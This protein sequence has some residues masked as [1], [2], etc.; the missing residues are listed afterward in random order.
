[1]GAYNWLHTPVQCYNCSQVFTATL[2]VPIGWCRYDE[3][4]L[5]DHIV[6]MNPEDRERA[7]Q[8][9][10]LRT[11]IEIGSES[12]HNFAVST[13]DSHKCPNCGVKGTILVIV[14]DNIFREVRFTAKSL[15]Y[16]EILL[17]PQLNEFLK[18]SNIDNG[19]AES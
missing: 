11:L 12:W 15:P 6:W 17:I 2:Q 13:G 1:M 3:Y 16:G 19:S 4:S 7:S 5:G 8:H 10:D 14:E 9:P 18:V